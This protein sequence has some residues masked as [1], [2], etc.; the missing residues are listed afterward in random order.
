MDWAGWVS[1]SS[2]GQVLMNQSVGRLSGIEKLS[3][4]PGRQAFGFR[5]CVCVYFCVH[6]LDSTELLLSVIC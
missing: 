5:V 1:L 4:Y 3:H 6:R 2:D